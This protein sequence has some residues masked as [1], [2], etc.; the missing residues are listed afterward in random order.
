LKVEVEQP[1][2]ERSSK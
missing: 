1:E 2:V